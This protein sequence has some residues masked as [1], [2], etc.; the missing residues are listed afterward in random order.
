MG[1]D[2]TVN[3]NGF[4]PIR[5]TDHINLVILL[6]YPFLNAIGGFICGFIT[7]WLYNF[8]AHQ[9]GGIFIDIVKISDDPMQNSWWI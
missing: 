6:A 7:V 5:F 9:W 3:L 2:R 4:V 8:Y 1:P